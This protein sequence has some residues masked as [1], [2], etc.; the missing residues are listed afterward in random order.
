VLAPAFVLTT[1]ECWVFGHK[2]TP[3]TQ[4]SISSPTQVRPPHTIS[5]QLAAVL[6]LFTVPNLATG[7]LGA[8]SASTAITQLAYT[9]S[10]TP[11]IGGSYAIAAAYTFSKNQGPAVS[12]PLASIAGNAGANTVALSG[13]WKPEAAGFI[14]SISW[15]LSTTAYKTLGELHDTVTSTWYTGLQWDDAFIKGNSAGMAV[16]QAPMVTYGANSVGCPQNGVQHPCAPNDSN[17]VWEWWYKFQVTD[18]ISVTPAIYYISNLLGQAGKVTIN[19]SKNADYNAFG[20]L[21]KTTF[22]F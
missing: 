18:N 2:P 10:N 16:G 22:K 5:L 8:S 21:I 13:Y 15:G 14:P 20:G 4:F 17:Y 11:L 7:L 9:G 12:T 3:Q 6:A 1:L 19:P